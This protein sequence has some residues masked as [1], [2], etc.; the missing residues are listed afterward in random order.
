MKWNMQETRIEIHIH[1]HLHI[2]IY[3]HEPHTHTHTHT[4]I[5]QYNDHDTRVEIGV[6]GWVV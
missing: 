4:T 6:G 3:I 2:H 1:I 5:Q